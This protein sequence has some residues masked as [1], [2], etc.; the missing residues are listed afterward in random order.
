MLHNMSEEKL[1]VVSNS[2]RIYSLSLPL[3]TELVT[4]KIKNKYNSKR[5]SKPMENTTSRVCL[6]FTA[7]VLLLSAGECYQT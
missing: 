1:L 4:E 3:P 5:N 2:P 6:N 7:N